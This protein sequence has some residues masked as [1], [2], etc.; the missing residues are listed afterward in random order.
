M[1][2]ERGVTCPACGASG[3][4]WCDVSRGVTRSRTW[5][6]CVAVPPSIVKVTSTK[7]SHVVVSR[8]M[9]LAA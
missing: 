2:T 9:S 7:P 3:E 4:R 5:S 8:T 1:T 6:L